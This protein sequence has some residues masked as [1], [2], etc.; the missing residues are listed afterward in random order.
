MKMKMPLFEKA[1]VLVAGDVMLDQYWQGDVS[2]ISPEAPVPVVHVQKI[3][4]RVGGA[5]N[6]ALNIKALGGSAW[7]L[8]L[9]GNDSAAKSIEE[10]LDQEQIAN[11]LLRVADVSTISKLRVVSHNQQLLRLDLEK[12]FKGWQDEPFLTAYLTQLANSDLVVLS[13]YGKGTLQ[14]IAKLI[15]LAKKMNKPVLV[16]PKS[17]DFS[18]YHGA[19]VVTPNFNEFE[20]V[21]GKCYSEKEITAKAIELLQKHEFQAILITRG[22]DGMSLIHKD[23][24]ALRLDA[25]AREVYDVTGAGDTVV[26]TLGAAMAAGAELTEA[27]ALANVAAGEVVKKLG[28]TVIAI[29][30]LGRAIQRQQ[31]FD[32]AV[33]DEEHLL[34]RLKD[35]RAHGEKI[36]MTNGCFDILHSGHVTY[37]EQ[38]KALGDRLVVAVN[39]DASVARLKGRTRPINK[40]K[41][42]MLVLA[43]LGSVDW[44]VPF[45]EDTPARLIELVSPNILVKGGDYKVHEIAGSDH[46]LGSGGE[47]I[48]VPF[49]DGFSTSS[50]LDRIACSVR[51]AEKSD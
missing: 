17:R 36:V 43:A 2:R 19:T 5:G 38:A 31:S 46:V 3:E 21:V 9:V 32:A 48:I 30:D 34:Q 28:T 41:E 20:A 33:L 29:S 12:H 16:D 1:R 40:L 51:A 45:S 22:A 7:L 42:R 37:L 49:S 23:K 13:D 8:G 18:I 39:D 25:K 50:M 24:K 47:V 11:C 4:E 35:V 14:N 26:A 6:V 15:A 10:K 44:V 27:V